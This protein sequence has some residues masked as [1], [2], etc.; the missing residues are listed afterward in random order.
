[1]IYVRIPKEVLSSVTDLKKWLLRS[2][3]ANKCYVLQICSNCGMLWFDP[4]AYTKDAK[5]VEQCGNC[6]EI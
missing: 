4:E 5:I 2:N 3:V 6:F 1:M